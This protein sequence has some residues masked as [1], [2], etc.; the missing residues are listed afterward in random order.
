MGQRFVRCKMKICKYQLVLFNETV[1][2]LDWLF[3][4]HDHLGCAENGFSI[5]E[6]FCTCTNIFFIVETAAFTGLGLQINSMSAFYK[7]LSACWGKGNTV[8]IIFNF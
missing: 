8:L 2:L 6:D 1:F 4:F 7:F 3:H 5:N